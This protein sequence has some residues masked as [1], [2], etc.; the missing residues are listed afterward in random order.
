V[1]ATESLPAQGRPLRANLTPEE[2][3]ALIAQFYPSVFA[4]D[5]TIGTITFVVDAN[6][7]YV[8]SQ[9]LPTWGPDGVVTMGGDGRGGAVTITRWKTAQDGSTQ[10]RINVYQGDTVAIRM[11]ADGDSVK[12]AELK[13][14]M[15]AMKVSM[16]NRGG[17]A[18][19]SIVGFAFGGGRG[20]RGGA[21]FL[22]SAQT[23]ARSVMMKAKR[24]AMQELVPSNI[25]PSLIDNV[26]VQ[27]FGPG[28]LSPNPLRVVVVE[29][30]P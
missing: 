2:L 14:T 30:K 4:G 24:D 1:A 27:A 19:D 13:K 21:A 10:N 25:D 6:H 17:G 20:G 22:D 26:Q 23:S 29:L 5:T 3:R 9:T 8:M 15:E 11:S 7:R 16:M 12:M 28:M 18:S